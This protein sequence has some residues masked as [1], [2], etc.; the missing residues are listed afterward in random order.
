MP[1]FDYNFFRLF[2]IV[3]LILF[4]A[5]LIIEILVPN[6]IFRGL[7]LLILP[8]P[9]FFLVLQCD[10]FFFWVILYLLFDTKP[11]ALVLGFL[12][13]EQNV[14]V[15]LKNVLL[16]V[17]FLEHFIQV[18]FLF[19]IVTFICKSCELFSCRLST[20]NTFSGKESLMSVHSSSNWI[21]SG[22][23]VLFCFVSWYLYSF[24]RT[25]IRF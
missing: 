7:F 20:L 22:F 18:H 19:K 21:S 2:F 24:C 25:L 17:E 12:V 16:K 4:P 23:T 15:R 6:H 1:I 5:F 14:D 3:F 11:V 13:L 9:S 8:R 10:W